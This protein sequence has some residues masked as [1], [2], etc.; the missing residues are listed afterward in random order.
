MKSFRFI[1][2]SAI[3]VTI[4]ILFTLVACGQS[5]SSTPSSTDASAS[6]TL[7]SDASTKTDEKFDPMT[8]YDQV[9]EL[10]AV[11]YAET[12]LKF[13]DGESFDNNI[14]TRAWENELGIKVKNL[15]VAPK[16]EYDQKLNISIAS[17]DLPDI[18]WA[19]SKQ[20][21]SIVDNEMAYD[22]TDV[23]EKYATDLTKEI[24]SQD[25]TAFD[26][27][28]KGGRLMAI[29]SAFSSMDAN[30][31]LYYRSDWATKLG[32]TEPKTIQDLVAMADAFT[33]KDPDGNSKKDTIGLV[34]NKAFVKDTNNILY[35]LSGFFAGYHAYPKVWV[36]DSSGQLVYG[37]ILPEAKA[38]LQQLQ[39]MY[40]AGTVDKE[41]GVKDV[42]KEGEAVA[43][44]KAGIVYGPMWAPLADLGKTVDNISGAE[45]APIALVSAD[46]KVAQPNTA[47]N[48]DKD[49]IVNK[50][51]KNPEAIVKLLNFFLEKSFGKTADN[52]Y[53]TDKDGIQ[54]FQYSLIGAAPVKKNLIAHDKITE[55][56]KAN[57]ASTLNV[58]EKGYYEKIVAF[59]GGDKKSANWGFVRVFGTPSSFDII[60]KYVTEN[61]ML[62]DGFYGAPTDTMAEKKATLEQLEDEVFTK[63]IMGQ[64]LDSFDK[65]VA[66][67]KKLGGDQITK[68]VNEWAEKN[69]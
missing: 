27:A 38:A 3:L 7:T 36:K 48:V 23:Y 15:W 18:I 8:K 13:K 49:Y 24:M 9:V 33:N 21:S 19:N 54:T 32:I 62:Y 30:P 29:A 20:L 60:G 68:E 5:G 12:T 47:I 10:T 28:K 44:G 64:S 35:G 41:F 58:E 14:Y 59:N 39:D 66:D 34:F 61:T 55:A 50:S 56:L 43:A 57:D 25:Q 45:W 65:F 40:K 26:T 22:L 17:G 69:K 11:R 16:A 63:I 42:A 37:S 53:G 67:W 46:D 51:C 52:E 6:T 1:K 31:I 4:C 2:L